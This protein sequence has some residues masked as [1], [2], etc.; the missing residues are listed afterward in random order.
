MKELMVGYSPCPNDTFIFY[1]LVHG[2][3]DT[4][5]LTFRQVL[6]DVETLNIMA[7]AG[8][9][10]ITKVSFAAFAGLKDSYAL[11]RSGGALG[12]GCGPLLVARERVDMKALRGK[13]IA[14]P[15]LN[16]TAFMLLRLLDPALGENVKAM[17]FNGIMP[18]VRDGHVDA[19]LIIHES[20]FTY[21]SFGLREVEDLGRWWERETG[22]PI[23]LGCIIARRSLGAELALRV[24]ALV[25]KSIEYSFARPGEPVAYIKAH[26]Q[27]MEDDVIKK[28]I[29]LYV[30]DYS[31]DLGDEGVSAVEALFRMAGD[32]GLLSPGG[33]PLFFT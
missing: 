16:T 27:E 12:R 17:P 25:R 23:P 7:S 24:E 29:G 30:N 9:L 31:L 20:R 1:A 2:K 18:A 22:H 32:K 4:G 28:H 26:S 11:L 13:L 10:D 6:D 5:G 3:V 14:V 33:R 19:G 8:K 21:R 15:G